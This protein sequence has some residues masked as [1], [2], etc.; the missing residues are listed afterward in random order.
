VPAAL[1]I[2]R[3]D[4]RTVVQAERLRDAPPLWPYVRS[5]DQRIPVDEG[6]SRAWVAVAQGARMAQ[7]ILQHIGDPPPESNFAL[8]NSLYANEKA[9]D[10]HRSYLAAALEHLIVWADFAAPLKFHP[11]QQIT[12]TFRPAYTLGRAAIEAASQA[13][14]MTSGN[15]AHECARRHLSLIRWDY[16]EHRKSLVGDV[17]A[18]KRVTDMDAQL[19]DRTARQFSEKELQPPSHYAVLRATAQLVDLE[20]DQLER[21]WRAASGSAHGKVWPSL[22]LQHVVPLSEYEQGQF[23]TLRIPDLD[24]MTEVLEV[25]EKLTMQGVLRHADFCKADIPRLIE[26]ARV[27]LASVITFREDADPDA[28]ARLMRREQCDPGSAAG[29]TLGPPW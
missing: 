18:Q 9:S 16:T 13:V 6:T 14:W 27:W 12:H 28:L 20:P 24:G 11:E 26:E 23:R 2:C 25:A 19:L 15:S 10:W 4:V 29:S 8:V 22:A 5:M 3:N 17:D 21:I 7:H 1:C